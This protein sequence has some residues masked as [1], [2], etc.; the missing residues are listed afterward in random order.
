[1]LHARRRKFSCWLTQVDRRWRLICVFFCVCVCVSPGYRVTLLGKSK[2][3]PSS[4]VWLP[5]AAANQTTDLPLWTRPHCVFRVQLN[6]F[7]AANP[8]VSEYRT[9]V[10]RV[11]FVELLPEP[12]R[13][14][15]T[16]LPPTGTCARSPRSAQWR[17]V[18][19]HVRKWAMKMSSSTL[20]QVCVSLCGFSVPSSKQVFSCVSDESIPC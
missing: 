4:E 2:Q 5:H 1:M 14:K 13:R 16:G 3:K 12:R 10:G 8:P 15:R 7:S 18:G 11:D 17:L 20:S 6:Q 9:D 19:F